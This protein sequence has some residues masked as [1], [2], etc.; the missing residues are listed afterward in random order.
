MSEVVSRTGQAPPP[1]VGVRL[2]WSALPDAVRAAVGERIGGGPVVEAVTQPGGFSPGVAARIRSA[3]GRR[4]FV[5]AVSARQNPDSPALHRAE[6]RIAAALPP[7]A[8]APRL[9]ADFEADGYVVMV[10]EDIDGHTPEQPWRPDDLRRAVS[11]VADMAKVLDPSPIEVAPVVERLTALNGWH[12]LAEAREAGA[13]GL[14]WLDPWARRN[15]ERLADLEAGWGRGAAGTAL[16]HADL[17][18]DNM[19]LTADRVV[20]VDWPWACTAAPWFDLAAMA[21]SVWMQGGP[22]L[23]RIV[24]EHPLISQADPDAVATV[25]AALAGMFLHGSRR[26]APVGLPTLRAFQAGQGVAA[27]EWVR[28]LRGWA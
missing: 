22:E 10:F 24:T 4:A 2:E 3:D 21:P 27:L 19:L 15:L 23:G 8:P 14:Q 1:A 11:A 26:P 18:A 6:A 12:Q 28:Q 9:L 17:R 25:A 20:I 7:E 5:K 16:A 13:D